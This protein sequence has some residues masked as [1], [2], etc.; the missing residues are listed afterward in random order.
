MSWPVTFAL[1][2]TT[3]VAQLLTLKL[4]RFPTFVIFRLPAA[5]D[6]S[7][8]LFAFVFVANSSGFESIFELPCATN[9]PKH[10]KNF[11]TQSPT[12]ETSRKRR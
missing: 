6:A 5:F 9:F 3:E 8:A 11:P 2:L 4:A 7:I 1:P 12:A 10:Y